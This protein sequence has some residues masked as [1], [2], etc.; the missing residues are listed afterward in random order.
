M[1]A[2]F[3]A[4]VA[5]GHGGEDH[6]ASAPPAAAADGARVPTWSSEFDAVVRLDGVHAGATGRGTLLVARHATS[7]PVSE[8]TATFSLTGPAD[9]AF[10]AAAGDSPGEWPFEAMFPSSGPW[11][12]GITVVHHATGAQH[13]MTRQSCG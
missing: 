13:R 7:E 5:M 12:G 8:G 10:T 9:L 2:W 1:I 3:W 11:S 6:G 4:E